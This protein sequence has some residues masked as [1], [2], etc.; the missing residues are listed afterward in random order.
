MVG[1]ASS[2]V[3]EVISDVPQ[4]SILGSLLFLIMMGDIDKSVLT[5]FFSSFA[6]TREGHG[7]KIMEDL[8]NFQKDL[9]NIYEWASKNSIKFNS[10]KV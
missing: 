8:Q 5:A 4:G 6:D 10:S 1:G 9:D 3:K 2:S 7:V